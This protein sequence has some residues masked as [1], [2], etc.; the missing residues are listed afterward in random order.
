MKPTSNTGATLA[1]QKWQ[2]QHFSDSQSELVVDPAPLPLPKETQPTV[3]L[4]QQ[5]E[6]EAFR[7]QVQQEAW[8]AGFAAGKAEGELQGYHQG[9][10]RAQT[11]SELKQQ[12]TLSA[13]NDLFQQVTLS[14]ELLDDAVSNRLIQLALEIAHQLTGEEVTHDARMVLTQVKQLL[15]QEALLTGPLTLK[16]NPQDLNL[17][18]GQLPSLSENSRCE[19]EADAGLAR[20]DCRL[21]SAEGEL[22]SALSHRWQA[23]CA[24]AKQGAY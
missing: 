19:I 20:G 12:Q 1:W 7:E 23:L 15:A 2:P 4:D 18:V 6:L 3:Q 8:Q 5:R 16:V 10:E 14:F 21:M 9:M 13:L 11:E 24:R 17:L 22:E